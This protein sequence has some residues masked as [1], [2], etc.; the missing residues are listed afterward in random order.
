MQQMLSFDGQVFMMTVREQLCMLNMEEPV[1]DV[2][3]S[4]SVSLSNI[5]LM[6]RDIHLH[7]R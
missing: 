6:V 4:A 3:Q 1:D 2:L 7:K 5:C